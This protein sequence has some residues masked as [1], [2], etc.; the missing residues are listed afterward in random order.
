MV[1]EIWEDYKSNSDIKQKADRVI[2]ASIHQIP[3]DL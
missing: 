3:E 2:G 1:L